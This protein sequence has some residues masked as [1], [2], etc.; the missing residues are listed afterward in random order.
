MTDYFD[1]LLTSPDA[2]RTAGLALGVTAAYLY[3]RR[4][5]PMRVVTVIDGDTLMVADKRGRDYK[6]RIRG[7]DCPEL[8]QRMSFEAKDFVQSLLQGKWV[9]V[10]FYGR[11]KYRRHVARV[12]LGSLD[13]S[14]ELV[15][16]GLAFPLKG[17]GLALAGLAA[18]AAGK[19]VWSGG[20]QAKPWEST[21]R[22][23][24]LL[25]FLNH[26]KKFRQVRRKQLEKRH[27]RSK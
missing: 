12:T 22:E 20:G 23:S 18:R 3:L 21:S 25:G 17:S 13:L 26:S 4:P 27:Q 24:S 8:G 19:G 2:L 11:D 14:R 16:H 7:V 10:K 1:T 5:R 15:R 9:M 6:L